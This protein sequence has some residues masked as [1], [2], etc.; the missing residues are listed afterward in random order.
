[1]R[2]NGDAGRLLAVV[3]T[4]VVDP[5]EVVVRERRR[6]GTSRTERWA[7]R[8]VQVL[9]TTA[10]NGDD[11]LLLRFGSRTLAMPGPRDDVLR[12]AALI[13]HAMEV[14]LPPRPKGSAGE[15]PDELRRLAGRE[16]S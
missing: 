5:R 1:M 9:G 4:I 16:R 7:L 8:D 12:A 2:R 14:E 10:V 11:C 15:V 3:R 13:C 6:L